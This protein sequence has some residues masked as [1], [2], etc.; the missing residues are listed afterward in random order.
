MKKIAIIS[1]GLGSLAIATIL[2]VSSVGAQS[3]TTSMHTK[4]IE[5]IAAKFNLKQEDVQKVFDENRQEAMKSNYDAQLKLVEEAQKAGKITSEQVDLFKKLEQY[6]IDNA[7]SMDQNKEDFKSLS[8]A[9]RK[10]KMD[11][12]KA[13]EA[14]AVGSTVEK[15]DALRKALR[16]AGV[17]FMGKGM[18]GGRGEMGPGPGA[19]NRQEQNNV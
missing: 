9:E 19:D 2:G 15:M 14:K 7:P 8:I 3:S 13:A 1:G 12:R 6:R 11:E 18:H 16:D 5:K 4:L 17:G 10:Q